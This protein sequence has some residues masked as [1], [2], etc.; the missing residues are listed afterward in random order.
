M[1][2]GSYSPIFVLLGFLHDIVYNFL[3]VDVDVAVRV[4]LSIEDA[5]LRVV[6][7]YQ[8]EEIVQ[9]VVRNFSFKSCG[10]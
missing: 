3:Q 4:G 9:L 1:S 2:S 5:A 10:K 8:I 6:L 7:V